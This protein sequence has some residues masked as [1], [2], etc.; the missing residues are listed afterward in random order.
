MRIAIIADI[1]GNLRALEA[2]TADIEAREADVV[3]VAGDIV[4]RGPLSRECLEIVLR[5]QRECGWR[6][7]RGNHEDYVLTESKPPPDRPEWIAKLCQ[8]SAW[9]CEKL[10]GLLDSVAALPHQIDF[11]SPEGQHICCV[12]ASQ[13]G[14][15]VGMFEGMDDDELHALI[16]PPDVSWNSRASAASSQPPD[17]TCVGHT[18]VPFIRRV[19]QRLVINSGAAGMPFDGDVRSGYGW[20][21]WQQH[22]WHAQIV[23]LD[24]D[25]AAAARDYVESGFLAEGGPIARLIQKEFERARPMLSR[26]HREYE[27]AVSNGQREIGETVRELLAKI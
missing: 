19:N 13:H 26:W 12:H 15:R 18:H 6:V 9:T 2:V 8:H 27:A 10:S 22:H 21:E 16:V 25:R 11:D 1:H 24:Y 5:K 7:I 14:N 23:R 4:N 3:L 20:L 17:V